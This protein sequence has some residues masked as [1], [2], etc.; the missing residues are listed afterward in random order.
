MAELRVAGPVA[1]D[2]CV[3]NPSRMLGYAGEGGA[4]AATGMGLARLAGCAGMGAGLTVG[5]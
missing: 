4:A 5:R 2:G 1:G 3:V